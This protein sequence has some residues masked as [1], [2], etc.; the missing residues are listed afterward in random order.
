LDYAPTREGI[1]WF[2]E[3]VWPSVKSAIPS[4]RLRLVGKD[5]DGETRLRGV[6]I[7]RLGWVDDVGTEI[8]SWSAMII[9]IRQ[10]GGTRIKIAEGFARRCPVISTRF[11]AY[12]YSLE[13]GKEAMLADSPKFFSQACIDLIRNTALRKSLTENAYKKY[14]QYWTWEA[15]ADSIAKA[16]SHC[17]SRT[18]M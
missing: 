7:D 6:D 12:G 10:G 14:L 16:V 15:Q 9:P 18:E 13:N 8:A 4:A 11:G 3:K 17:L 5:A 2:I 1:A